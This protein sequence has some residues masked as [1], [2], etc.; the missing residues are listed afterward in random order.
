[1]KAGVLALQGDVREHLDIIGRG[2][3]AAVPVRNASD[4]QA[5]DALI[6]PGGESTT[7]GSLLER[8]EMLDP[9]RKR[10]ESGMPAFGTCAG[11][12]LLA[13]EVLGGDVPR[14]GGMDLVVHRNAYG[15][16]VDSFEED[17]DV[18][19]L[20][21]VRGAFIRAPRIEQTG[22]SV[23]V[24]AERHGRAVVV[25]EGHLLAAT[26]H[27]EITGDDRLHR[28][29]LEEICGPAGRA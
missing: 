27:P 7:I 15:R 5:I 14:P 3:C 29:F 6:L 2:G 1:M 11:A 25:R 13:R 8:H 26:F 24:L 10:I 22:E 17:V 16:Q 28:W 23:D 18:R 12:I 9:L 4:L 20:G 21:T 19:G